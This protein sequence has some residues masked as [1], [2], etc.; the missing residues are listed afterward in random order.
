MAT[1]INKTQVDKLQRAYRSA[2]GR[3]KRMKEQS[4][5]IAG[6]IQGAALTGGSAFA[7]GYAQHR[8]RDDEGRPGIEVLGVPLDLGLGL[9]LHVAGIFG[10]FGNYGEAARSVANGALASYA[11][12][13]GAALGSKAYSELGA[14]PAT[15]G[16]APGL[17]GPDL[18]QYDGV[19]SERI[20]DIANF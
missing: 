2:L 11:T 14:S 3:A 15:A 4:T 20:R 12:T 17:G 7:L 5:E 16:L 19:S 10:M 6:S 1:K 18:G 8:F 9:G 13:M